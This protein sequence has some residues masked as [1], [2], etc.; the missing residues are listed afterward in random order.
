MRVLLFMP[1]LPTILAFYYYDIVGL[2]FIDALYVV[3][4]WRHLH[5]HT[6]ICLPDIA[7]IPH[8]PITTTLPA[9]YLAELLRICQ[10]VLLY[11]YLFP[12]LHT[13]TFITCHYLSVFD[14]Y[15]YYWMICLCI[16]L[17]DTSQLL[18]LLLFFDR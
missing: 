18:L 14:S 9:P 2:H 7:C 6:R 15:L 4:E 16:L 13:H 12:I 11:I 3:F 5:I 8:P 10:H 1:Y 17:L